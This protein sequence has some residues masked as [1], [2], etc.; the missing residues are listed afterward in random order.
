[1]A[2][3]AFVIGFFPQAGLQLVIDSVQRPLGRFI[4]KLRTEH[5]LSGFDGLNIWDQTRLGEEG[6]EDMQTLSSANFVDLML[7]TRAPLAR[8]VDWMDQAFLALHIWPIAG[9][10]RGGKAPKRSASIDRLRGR[11]SAPPPTWR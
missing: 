6:I 7:K 9:E 2:L 8:L 3:I 4:P 5:P 11:A 10:S 1:M